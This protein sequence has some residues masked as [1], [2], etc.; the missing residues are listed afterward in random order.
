MPSP[1]SSLVGV[2]EVLRE[3]IREDRGSHFV[4]YRP[5]DG[6]SYL[7]MLYLVFPGAT[8]NL[9]TV[10]GLMETELD[11][12]VQRFAVPTMVWAWDAA[13]NQIVVAEVTGDSLLVG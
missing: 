9:A 5:A 1:E 13:E 4:E 6:V 2:P 12:W 11:H 7:A 10:A 8:P 3:T